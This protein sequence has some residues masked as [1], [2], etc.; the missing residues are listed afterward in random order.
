[1]YEGLELGGGGGGQ[2]R[3]LDAGQLGE[4]KKVR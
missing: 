2:G 4:G 1:V 3:E